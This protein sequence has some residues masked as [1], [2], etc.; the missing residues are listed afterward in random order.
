M[1]SAMLKDY[2]IDLSAPEAL[3]VN[4]HVNIS[5]Y[6]P[7]QLIHAFLYHFLVFGVFWNPESGKIELPPANARWFVSITKKLRIIIRI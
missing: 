2:T 4:L 5:A 7:F 3:Q 1:I 6:S